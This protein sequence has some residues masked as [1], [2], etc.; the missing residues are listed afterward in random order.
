MEVKLVSVFAKLPLNAV[1]APLNYII[2]AL[3]KEGVANTS[4]AHVTFT[5]L[6]GALELYS[7]LCGWNPLSAGYS[8]RSFIKLLKSA[9][10]HIQLS[11]HRVF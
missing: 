2:N 4:Y 10:S 5:Q 1:S 11:A 8:A 6:A 9:L 7:Y 3:D